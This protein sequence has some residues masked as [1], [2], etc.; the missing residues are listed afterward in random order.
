MLD[1]GLPVDVAC[2]IDDKARQAWALGSDSFPKAGSGMPYQLVCERDVAPIAISINANKLAEES[3]KLTVKISGEA[4]KK[5]RFNL[6]FEEKE[7]R[8]FDI[9]QTLIFGGAGFII[10]L[11]VIGLISAGKVKLPW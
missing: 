8:L 2:V 11:M 1:L 4:D 9:L 10:V 6:N 3:H 7:N 5:S